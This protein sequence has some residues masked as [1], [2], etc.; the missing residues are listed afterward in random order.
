VQMTEI[1]AKTFD[2]A[3]AGRDVLARSRTGTGKTIAFLLPALERIIQFNN[4]NSIQQGGGIQML[5]LCPTRELALQIAE[6]TRQLTSSFSTSSSRTADSKMAITQQVMFGGSSRNADVSR[7]KSCIP[8]ILIATPGRI[9]DHLD[10]TVIH[11]TKHGRASFASLFQHT[12]LLVL[13][14]M[15]RLLD[16]GFRLPV[17]KILSSLPSQEHRQTLLFSAT[18]PTDVRQVIARNLKRDFVTVDCI[19]DADPASHTNNAVQQSH[20]VAHRDQYV[21]ATV[22]V[23]LHILETDPQAKLIVFFPTTKMVKFYAELFNKGVLSGNSNKKQ[24]LELHS[25]KTQAARTSTSDAFRKVSKETGGGVLFTS[26]V[27]ARGV[28]YKDVTHVVQVGMADSRETYI[29][30]KFCFVLFV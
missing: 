14:E 23:L 26:D 20:V 18:L 12:H 5:I 22:R 17:E 16:M 15:D 9:Q 27:S 3:V 7:L 11:S 30:R 25:G 8:T 28:D 21:E 4:Q 1:Q 10:N 24:V 19:H 2:A 13:D 29:H 6:Q